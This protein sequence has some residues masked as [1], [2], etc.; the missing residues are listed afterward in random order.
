MISFFELQ[1]FYSY[2]HNKQK[3]ANYLNL[4]NTAHTSTGQR[5]FG[6]ENLYGG[7]WSGAEIN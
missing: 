4:L 6:V 1:I 7:K 2:V 5:S 3:Y